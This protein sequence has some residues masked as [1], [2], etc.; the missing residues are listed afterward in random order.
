MLMTQTANTKIILNKR[1]IFYLD[2]T[3]RFANQN[4]MKTM[5]STNEQINQFTFF[6]TQDI[7]H[8]P[9]LYVE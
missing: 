4:I 6:D 3:E 9:R 8:S 7:G 5:K 2:I 1:F